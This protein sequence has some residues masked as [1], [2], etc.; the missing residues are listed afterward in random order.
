MSNFLHAIV[1]FEMPMFFQIMSEGSGAL[2]MTIEDFE[3]G[4]D[5]LNL[6]DWLQHEKHY[7][8]LDKALLKLYLT[9]TYAD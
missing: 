6:V 5:N 1:D 7:I 8:N 4:L 3:L 2:S 9:S